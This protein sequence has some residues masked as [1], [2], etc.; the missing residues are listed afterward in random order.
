MTPYY[1]DDCVTL[2]HGRWQDVVAEFDLRAD[3]VLSDPPYSARTHT[4]QH[5]GRKE[6]AYTSGG[7][8]ILASRWID[9]DHMTPEDVHELVSELVPRVSGWHGYMTD[10]E[11]TTAYRDAFRAHGLTDFKP[12]HV[13]L[14]GQNVRLAG[15]GPSSWGV[16]MSCG[17]VC[18]TEPY[19]HGAYDLMV[20][21]PKHLSR[22]SGRSTWGTLPG[23][24][25]GYPFDP[26]QNAL[27]RSKGVVGAKPI[28]LMQRVIGD[29]S[30]PGDTVLDPFSGGGTTGIAARRLGRKAILIE[31]RE[32]VCELAAKRLE[33][34]SK[35]LDLFGAVNVSP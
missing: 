5:H 6:A 4:G 14:K 13:V 24:Y 8:P 31:A 19:E 27:D 16:Y 21:R 25:T 11:L 32:G 22:S 33:G 3:C 35:Q 17:A 23:A 34:E 15:D 29:Y 1:Q 9:Y 26:G 7:R 28:W 10:S 12:V 2:Y 18:V 20:A 30:R